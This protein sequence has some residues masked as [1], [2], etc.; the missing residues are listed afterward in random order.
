M[1]VIKNLDKTLA[2]LDAWAKKAEKAVT[3]VARGVAVRAFNRII[4]TGPQFSGDF[5]ANM[6]LSLNSAD[7]TF[8]EGA[9]GVTKGEPFQQGSRPAIQY[10]AFNAAVALNGFKLGDKIIIS[11]SARHK[12]DNYAFKIENDQINFRPV[13]PMGGSTFKKTRA[14]IANTYGNLSLAQIQQLRSARLV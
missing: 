13:N 3:Q 9:L 12:S 2:Q 1:V 11:S 6:R 10:A 14:Q 4:Y 8:E 5:V 7:T